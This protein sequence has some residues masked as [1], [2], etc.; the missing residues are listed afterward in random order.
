MS[1]FRDRSVLAVV[2]R[3]AV[4]DRIE[5]LGDLLRRAALDSR[6][7]RWLR[8]LSPPVS[9]HAGLTLLVAAFVHV[10]IVG[11]VVGPRHGYW[12]LLPAMAAVAGILLI[13]VQRRKSV[14]PID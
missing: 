12:L 6:I 4:V 3:S 14:T 10:V 1:E 5:R 2:E 8:L 11:A 9:Q 13:I 7:L